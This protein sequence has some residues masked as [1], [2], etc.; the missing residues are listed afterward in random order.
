MLKVLI[1]EKGEAREHGKKEVNEGTL[2][3]DFLVLETDGAYRRGEEPKYKIYCGG[4]EIAHDKWDKYKIESTLI[5]IVQPKKKSG[6]FAEAFQLMREAGMTL[7][8]LKKSVPEWD[9]Y[10]KIKEV[11]IIQACGLL[12]DFDSWE[13]SWAKA[14]VYYASDSNDGEYYKQFVVAQKNRDEI[15]LGLA[16]EVM[17]DVSKHR[18]DKT[19]I[20]INKLDAT[21]EVRKKHRVLEEPKQGK[22]AYIEMVNLAEFGL[23]AKRAGYILPPRFP[24]AE[25]ISIKP[26]VKA[27][28]KSEDEKRLGLLRAWLAEEKGF[29]PHDHNMTQKLVW[30]ACGMGVKS[31]GTRRSFFQSDEARK[32]IS[33]ASGA[34]SKI[35]KIN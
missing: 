2:I 23:W 33:F 35:M 4:E 7:E 25:K 15:E 29:N 17:N 31:E 20:T 14:A 27:Q 24:V 21:E 28:R 32:L 8:T 22:K 18:K 19:F 26:D 5:I 6:S 30:D 10:S 13:H 1:K 12:V 3:E 11:P 16:S 34:R 9:Y